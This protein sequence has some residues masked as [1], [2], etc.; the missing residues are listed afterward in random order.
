M[1]PSCFDDNPNHVAAYSDGHWEETPGPAPYRIKDR[2]WSSIGSKMNGKLPQHYGKCD[3]VVEKSGLPPRPLYHWVPHQ[4]SLR[5][6]EQDGACR[7][8]SGKQVVVVGDST[9]FQSFLSL[10]LLLGGHF[11]QDLKHGFVIADLTASA[12]SDTTRL[13]FV[14]SDLLL[15]TQ[16]VSDKY[17]VQRCDGFTIL[18]PFIMRAS[19]DADIVILGVGHHIPRSLMLA[20][21]WSRWSGAVAA[22]KARVGFFVRNLNHTLTSLIARRAAWGRTD[23]ASVIVMGASTP[24]RGCANFRTPL[25]LTDAIAAAAGNAGNAGDPTTNELRWM[26]Y[27]RLNQLSRWMTMAVGASF[28]DV[29]TP[30]ALRPDGAMG[31]FWPPGNRQNEYDTTRRTSSCLVA[32]YLERRTLLKKLL[33]SN[34]T[35]LSCVH[36]CLPGVVDTWVTLLYNLLASAR[37]QRALRPTV[38]LDGAL[39]KRTARSLSSRASSRRFL[40]TN[41]SV[42]LHERGYSER[43]ETCKANARGPAACETSMQRRPWWAFYCH[44]PKDRPGGDYEKNYHPWQPPES[45]D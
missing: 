26:Q 44:E 6:Y 2:F 39:P 11:G 15:W 17:A 16:S 20:E 12:C 22:S 37:L 9:V 35:N 30:S 34:L 8:F 13:V 41:S 10:V 43:F 29:A 1:L 24:V 3:D 25:T 31:R 32:C 4:C 18:H 27:P 42:W 7:V 19:R 40:D 38:T 45:F 5:P 33:P 14:R 23:P 21:K 36:Y 28:I